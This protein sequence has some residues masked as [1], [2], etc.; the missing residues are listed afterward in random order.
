MALYLKEY[1]ELPRNN[2]DFSIIC[3]SIES[4]KPLNIRAEVSQ[5]TPFISKLQKNQKN[6][7]A[8]T[9]AEFF[10]RLVRRRKK[11]F[12]IIWI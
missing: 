12:D 8:V 7:N 1:N 6:S 2:V 3:I 5:D 4:K 9:K 11:I 10:S